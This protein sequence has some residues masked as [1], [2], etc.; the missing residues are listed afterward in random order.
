MAKVYDITG[1]SCAE[2][3][4]AE[5]RAAKKVAGVKSASAGLLS[6]TLTGEGDAAAAEIMKADKDSG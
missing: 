2:C 5:E 6:A 3:S 4:A 1:M